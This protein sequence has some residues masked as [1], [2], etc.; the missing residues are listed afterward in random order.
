[1]K[2]KENPAR[3]ARRGFLGFASQFCA[4]PLWNLSFLKN[5]AARFEWDPKDFRG[6][7][8]NRPGNF[9]R[10]RISLMEYKEKPGARSAPGDFRGLHLNFVPNPYQIHSFL[11]ISLPDSSGIL[12]ISG[13]SLVIVLVIP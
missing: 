3:E 13:E 8:S 4:K 10:T 7:T 2:S 1:M 6:I 12:R 11:M 9:M 5:S